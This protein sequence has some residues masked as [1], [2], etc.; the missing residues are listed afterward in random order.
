MGPNRVTEV[1]VPCTCCFKTR[2]Y[3]ARTTGGAGRGSGGFIGALG[4]GRQKG[5]RRETRG[6][7]GGKAPGKRH[8]EAGCTRRKGRKGIK[9]VRTHAPSSPAQE[10]QPMGPPISPALPATGIKRSSIGQITCPHPHPHLKQREISGLKSKP[11]GGA[12]TCCGY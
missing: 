12:L 11:K 6:G 1:P 4:C 8:K 5:R 10:I 7:K 2:T 9:A 3:Y